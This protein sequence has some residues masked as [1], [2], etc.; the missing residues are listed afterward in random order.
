MPVFL[1]VPTTD[2]EEVVHTGGQQR[3]TTTA[4]HV[5]EDDS[6]SAHMSQRSPR[7]EHANAETGDRTIGGGGHHVVN[8]TTSPTAL[9]VALHFGSVV[10]L[11]QA[12]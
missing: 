11:G 9:V 7:L 5:G 1:A 2:D 4:V 10:V 8:Q 12:A 6:R 3:N